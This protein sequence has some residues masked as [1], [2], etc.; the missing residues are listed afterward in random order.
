[1]VAI[2]QAAPVVVSTGCKN[3]K[4]E[5][6]LKS[7][8]TP[9]LEDRISLSQKSKELVASLNESTST[10]KTSATPDG[11][12]GKPA[13]QAAP[14]G[15]LQLTEEERQVVQDLKA[16]DQEV[17]AHEAA[18]KGAAGPYANGAPTY[19]YQ[20][21]PD[22]KRYAV[23]GEVSIDVSPVANNPSA[24]IQKAQTI[25]RAANAPQN[26]S[27][28]DRAVAAQASRLEAE[29]R[30]ELQKQRAEEQTQKL[31]DIKGEGSATLGGLSSQTANP[32][33]SIADP[34]ASTSALK[35]GPK[36]ENE[37]PSDSK[38]KDTKRDQAVKTQVSSAFRQ[39]F[40]ESDSFQLGSLLNV[41]S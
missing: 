10:G 14:A 35:S 37:D 21:G 6:G 36:V 22:G 1:M 5:E 30:K 40:S 32:A 3:C 26:P 34:S 17:R 27:S 31:Q 15:D 24:T 38:E 9:T 8:G 29:A 39:A 12:E 25:R 11:K 4:K 2:V 16:R 20:T 23:G 18:H 41:I 13:S 7:G 33:S 19:Q 28:Q